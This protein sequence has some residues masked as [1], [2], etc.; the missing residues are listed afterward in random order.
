MAE[1]MLKH[2]KGIVRSTE[3]YPVDFDQAWQWVGYARKDYALDTLKTNFKKGLDYSGLDRNR[4]DGEEGSRGQGENL[5]FRSKQ[6]NQDQPFAHGGKREG[7]GRKATAYFLTVDCFKSF[8]MMAGTDKGKEVRQYFLR[9]EKE[10]FESRAGVQVPEGMMIANEGVVENMIEEAV[11]YH[12]LRSEVDAFKKALAP[13]IADDRAALEEIAKRYWAAV[14][15]SGR[16][17]TDLERMK[18]DI[19]EIKED[20]SLIRYLI[21]KNEKLQRR[22][23]RLSEDERR[24]IWFKH[25][26]GMPVARIE[27]ETGRD[28]NSI[29]RIIKRGH[30]GITL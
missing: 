11:A 30:R 10:Y 27:R 23:T 2:F 16:L 19:A 17:Q 24:D 8:C 9:I 20:R 6:E 15:A 29:R 22:G 28:A 14:T 13:Q 26:Y 25:R 4:S 18:Q 1:M 3:R 21:D 5:I 7:A 12:R